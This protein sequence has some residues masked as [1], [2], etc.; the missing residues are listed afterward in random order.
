MIRIS[1]TDT[2]ADQRA[3]VVIPIYNRASVVRA[4]LDSVVCQTQPP[5]TLIVVDDGSTDGSPDAVEAWASEVRPPFPVRVIRAVHHTAANARNI[6]WRE[7]DDIPFVAF[8]DSDDCWPKDFLARTTELLAQH[9][10]AVAVTADRRFFDQR[11][12]MVRFDDCR[13]LVRDPLLWMF[14]HGA[15]IASCTL[16]RNAVVAAVGGWD[17]RY[18][19]AEDSVLFTAIAQLGEW[20][21]TPGAPVDFFHG[22]ALSRNEENNLSRRHADAYRRWAHTYESIFAGLVDRS[23]GDQLER[24]RAP[25][26]VYW[27]RAGKQLETLG[28]NQEAVDCYRRA[29]QWNRLFPRAWLRLLVQGRT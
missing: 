17:P 20:L 14:Q 11:G 29:V 4:T 18:G 6:G 22:N 2:T 7:L 21:H 10:Q 9:P 27:Y 26:A 24:L 15:G 25:L 23:N 5:E 1:N 3:G 28:C 19:A 13:R 12:T 16:L 8:L